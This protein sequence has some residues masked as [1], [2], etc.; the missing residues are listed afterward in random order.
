MYSAK[1]ALPRDGLQTTNN[2][3][4]GDPAVGGRNLKIMKSD[5]I[6]TL[7]A[8]FTIKRRVRGFAIPGTV[9]V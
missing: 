7:A 3:N 5:S 1:I 9:E 4:A 8:V 2:C 6:R